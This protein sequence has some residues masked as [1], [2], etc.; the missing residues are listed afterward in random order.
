[1]ESKEYLENFKKELDAKIQ[2][3]VTNEFKTE[4]DLYLKH[5][6]NVINGTTFIEY[7]NTLYFITGSRNGLAFINGIKSLLDS[8]ISLTEYISNKNRQLGNYVINLHKSDNSIEAKNLFIDYLPYINSA[9]NKIFNLLL[10]YTVLTHLTSDKINTASRAVMATY[11][12]L[13]GSELNLSLKVKKLLEDII[14]INISVGYSIGLSKKDILIYFGKR[15]KVS[16]ALVIIALIVLIISIVIA[17][18][19]IFCVFAAIFFAIKE[20]RKKEKFKY[21]RVFINTLLG[22]AYLLFI[23]YT[24]D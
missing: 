10:P 1:M 17:V 15:Y 21:S 9:F 22:P 5:S 6:N 2:T 18:I 8:F 14:V 20:E 4:W 12:V 19:Y 7:I 3:L 24:R 16:I 11:I 13:T 23:L